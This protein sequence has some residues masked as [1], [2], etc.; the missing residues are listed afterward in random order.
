MR[1]VFPLHSFKFNSGIGRITWG[2]AKGL[3]EK[4]VKVTIATVHFDGDATVLELLRKNNIEITYERTGEAN[5]PL[6]RTHQVINPYVPV[7]AWRLKELLRG[8]DADFYIFQNEEA[9]PLARDNEFKDRFIFYHLG[10]WSGMALVP[11]MF[12][13]F[14]PHIKLGR[15]ITLPGHFIYAKILQSVPHVIAV[16][17]YTSMTSSL[18]YG[19]LADEVIY[20]PVDTNI[21]RPS[22]E[23][24]KN[25]EAE[26]YALFIGGVE[27]NNVRL[28]DEIAKRIPLVTV[29][30]IKVKNA[31]NFE[32]V[33]LPKLVDL[34]SR[35]TVTLF[36]L[37]N[38]PYGYIPVESMACGTPV[39]AYNDG[40]PSETVLDGRTGW[41]VRNEREFFRKII[42]V[43]K[44]G[45]S[46]DMRSM[47]REHVVK[48]FS[49]ETA[50]L[51]LYH[52]LKKIA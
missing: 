24:G 45:V 32:F 30:G 10:L 39:I 21:F 42:E 25:N 20:P 49:I 4:G 2:L 28:L 51:K 44:T 52:F 40:G 34:Y 16:S 14:P 46:D 5:I 3:Q 37:F 43:F 23:K 38:E 29:G 17:N 15:I 35:A 36:P 50:S 13:S 26:P 9:L 22:K 18:L 48:N 8:I 27:T 6:H 33:K 31:K 47:C 7:Y 11:R 41:L 12:R 1:V 19:R